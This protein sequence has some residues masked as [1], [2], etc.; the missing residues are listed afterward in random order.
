MRISH[1]IGRLRGAGRSRR[2][3]AGRVH[4]TWSPVIESFEARTLLSTSGPL[5]IATLG[6][7]LTDEYQFYGPD[8]PAARNWVETLSALRAS[9]VDFGPFTAATNSGRTETHNQG[10]FQNWARS[11]AT[12]QG[13]D[14]AGANTT[15]VQQYEGD[16]SPGAPGLLNQDPADLAN[17]DVVT[18]L[19]GGNDY[20]QIILNALTSPPQSTTDPFI[21]QVLAQLQALAPTSAPNPVTPGLILGAIEQVVPLIQ[22][23]NPD[24]KIIL[25]STPDVGL[26]P[27]VKN[28][29]GTLGD[30]IEAELHQLSD[31]I[32]AGLSQYAAAQGLG[33]VNL[34]QLFDNFVANPVIDGTFINPLGAGPVYTDMF[35]GDSFHPGTIAQAILAN[36]IAEAINADPGI[37]S[38]RHITPLSDSEIVNFAKQVQP[39]T[40]SL[41]AA[42]SAV[43]APG[44]PVTFSV[45][46]NAF[47]SIPISV[48]GA[49]SVFDYP[50]PTGTVTFF[51][52]TQGNTILGIATLRPDPS[53]GAGHAFS[54]ATFTTSS[55]TPGT[56]QITAVYNGDTIYPS[57][58]PKGLIPVNTSG[59]LLAPNSAPGVTVYVGT[60]RQAELLSYI[61]LFQQNLGLQVTPPLLRRW[62]RLVDHGVPPQH[63]ARAIYKYAYRTTHLPR[64]RQAFPRVR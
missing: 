36:A 4:R 37:P 34:D 52:A 18:I 8:R 49:A 13:P 41:L 2:S 28:L 53:A 61:A 23:A 58:V 27:L 45:Q 24:I 7:S 57:A 31:Q 51:D 62:T 3:A 46:V 19:I 12:T 17:L 1:V 35:V 55:L 56:H 38:W 15:F 33:F 25:I 54:V 60:P 39:V 63:V 64:P 42:S 59:A 44:G 10:F 43:V 48:D 21:F 5:R 16:F 32:T 9:Q 30:A 40:Q 20:E 47:P 14:V 26:T 29:P 6:D 50:A 11:G 22:A